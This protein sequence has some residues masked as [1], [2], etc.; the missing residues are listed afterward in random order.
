[1]N[2]K[3]VNKANMV[4][5]IVIIGVIII[6]L[7]YSFFYLSAFWDPYSKLNNLPVALVNKDAGATISNQQ[8]NL[9][10]NLLM[11]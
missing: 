8:R 2:K 7:M 3:I 5:F 4:R 6:P 11:S 10:R 9:G 1:M